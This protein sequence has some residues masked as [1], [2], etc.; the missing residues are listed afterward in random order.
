MS[1][2]PVCPSCGRKGGALT[3]EPHCRN[4]NCDW[5][6]CNCGATYSRKNEAGFANKP[7]PVHYPAKEAS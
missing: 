3:A 2:A 6:K 5:N 1:I 7:E 4:V